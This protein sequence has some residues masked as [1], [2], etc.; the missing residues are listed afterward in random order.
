MLYRKEFL[1]NKYTKFFDYDVSKAHINF[2]TRYSSASL[3]NMVVGSSYILRPSIEDGIKDYSNM[4]IASV[5]NNIQFHE[6]TLF[7]ESPFRWIPTEQFE[8]ELEDYRYD[9]ILLNCIQCREHI[10]EY[11]QT[12]SV[13]RTKREYTE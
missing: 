3:T 8:D 7:H 2:G 5:Y 6:D 13:L 12:I 11:L 1:E 9:R 4:Y 10:Y